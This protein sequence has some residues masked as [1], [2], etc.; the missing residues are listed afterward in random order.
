MKVDLATRISDLLAYFRNEELHFEVYCDKEGIRI[1]LPNGVSLE[2]LNEI[3]KV[4]KE[5]IGVTT[6][7]LSVFKVDDEEMICLGFFEEEEA[8]A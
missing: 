1:Y 8:D 6:L 2:T 3:A 7:D 5:T 4:L